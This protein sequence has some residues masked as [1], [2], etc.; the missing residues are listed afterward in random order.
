MFVSSIL[1]PLLALLSDSRFVLDK[2]VLP[3]RLDLL[4]RLDLLARLDLL[5]GR[6][7]LLVKLDLPISVDSLEPSIPKTDFRN[8]RFFGLGFW[9]GECNGC[10]F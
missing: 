8:G 1:F 2:L 3:G 4:V 10:I 7:N 6:L 5:P 9:L